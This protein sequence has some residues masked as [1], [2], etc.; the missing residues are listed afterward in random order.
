MAAGLRLQDI[1]PSFPLP[2]VV[3][4]GSKL[5]RKGIQVMRLRLCFGCLTFSSY[6]EG[7]PPITMIQGWGSPA[8]SVPWSLTR[9]LVP[10][11]V[12]NVSSFH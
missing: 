9:P 5:E 8:Y 4:W 7:G 10:M 11:V 1:L 12:L 6:D 2:V 3:G